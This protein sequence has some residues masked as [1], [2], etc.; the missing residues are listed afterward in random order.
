MNDNLAEN[1]TS[2]TV[3]TEPLLSAY[4]TNLGKYNEGYLV[5]KW[6]DFPTTAE[7]IA[8]TFEE[9]GIDGVEYE[10]FFITDYETSIEGVH[11]Q[12]SEYASLSELNY[13]ATRVDEMVVSEREIYE[14]IIESGEYC[15]SIK[16]L[17]NLT[18]N[19]E[20]FDY[21]E[22]IEDEYDLGYYWIE[23]SGCYNTE[24]MGSLSNYIDYER[25][26]RDIAMD[27][28]GGFTVNGY[29]KSNGNSFDEEYDGMNVPDEYRLYPIP[30][31][32]KTLPDM[33]NKTDR[34]DER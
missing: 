21:Y 29:I 6:H 10:E 8:K 13:L 4:I 5:G 18:Y 14:A 16:D 25:F 9:I 12:L 3:Q 19:L 2:T 11:G 24:G 17:I 31:A 23:E 1:S 28:T 20:C 30:K 26:G 15:G 34:S 7:E 22:G 32:E 33:K 27:D